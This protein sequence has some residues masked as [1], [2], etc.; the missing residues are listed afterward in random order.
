[1]RERE[2]EKG[3]EKD[4]GDEEKERRRDGWIKG[5]KRKRRLRGIR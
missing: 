4:E 1:M 3:W 2:K 5:R